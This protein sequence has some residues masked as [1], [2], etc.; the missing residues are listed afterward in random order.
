MFSYLL[1]HTEI[2]GYFYLPKA[3]IPNKIFLTMTKLN[4]MGIIP[5]TENFFPYL[6]VMKI[7][8]KNYNKTL[9]FT[10]TRSFFIQHISLL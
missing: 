5:S 6:I 4:L 1:K 7:L 9:F 10:V 2:H 3:I 8:S